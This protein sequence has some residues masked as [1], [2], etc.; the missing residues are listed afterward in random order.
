[1][2]NFNLKEKDYNLVTK[3]EFDP[4]HPENERYYDISYTELIAPTI[5]A[6]QYLDK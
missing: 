4:N 2:K 1:M 5:K 6:V 3:P